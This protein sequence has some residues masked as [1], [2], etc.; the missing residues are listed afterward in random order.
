MKALVRFYTYL[1]ILSIDVALGAV[2]C[3]V[4]F[5][6]ILGVDILP[7]GIGA[8][9]LTVWII[10]TADHLRDAML[11]EGEAASARHRFHQRHRIVLTITLIIAI[12]FNLV[13]L[14]Y[15]RRELLF[16]GILLAVA[17]AVYL[18]FQRRFFYG[19]EIFVSAI[20]TAGVLLPSSV[21]TTEWLSLS[22]IL[23]IVAF[24]L[25]ALINLYLFSFFDHERDKRDR[26]FSFVT[27]IGP[28]KAKK[29]ISGL[30]VAF[31]AI[32]STYVFLSDYSLSSVCI[33]L[34]GSVLLWI[35]RNSDLFAKHE[36]YRLIGDA[37][38]FIPLMAV[39]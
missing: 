35:F 39:L 34:M 19:K 18:L 16:A 2:I 24:F 33:I 17:V 10:Y 36:R 25:V 28:A 32:A 5:S 23:V 15:I 7:Y 29:F 1:N 20:Y 11:I 12:G 30:F 4:F 8:L 37:V 21:S 9:A 13:L 31:F 27:F 26:L 22:E 14:F 38:F 3:A 6:K